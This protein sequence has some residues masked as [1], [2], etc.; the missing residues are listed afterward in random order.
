[1][2]YSL[3]ILSQ[4]ESERNSESPVS[5]P[6]VD[7]YEECVVAEEDTAVSSPAKEM[8]SDRISPVPLRAVTKRSGR[9]TKKGGK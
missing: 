7:C 8:I 4:M 6:D 3:Q 9:V 2:T 1:M 5:S